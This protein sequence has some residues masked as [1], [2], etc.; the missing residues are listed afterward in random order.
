MPDTDIATQSEY[1]VPVA[2]D[3]ATVIREIRIAGSS[4]SSTE[5][6]PEAH[7]FIVG[8]GQDENEDL[9]EKIECVVLRQAMKIQGEWNDSDQNNRHYMYKSSEFNSFSDVVVLYDTHSIPSR[10][11]A[12]L[13]HSHRNPNLPSIGGKGERALKSKCNLRLRYVY[14]ILHNEEVFRLNG[15][16]TS[17][18]GATENDKP[19]G[20]D[21]PQEGSF[22]QFI[23]D[24]GDQPVFKFNCT[25]SGKKHS[26]KIMLPQFTKGEEAAAPAVDSFLSELYEGLSEAHWT[27]FGKAIDAT[28]VKSLDEWSQKIIEILQDKTFEPL[29]KGRSRDLF[30]PS[31]DSLPDVV[32]VKLIDAPASKMETDVGEIAGALQGDRPKVEDLPF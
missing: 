31:L 17:Y 8:Y 27:V 3:A 13:P 5:D 12:A 11:V 7:P 4:M 25:L 16:S 20:F 10:I 18:T 23:R 24:C 19:F 1:A 26:K 15:G 28:D 6:I 9:G 2:P 14:Y 32:D 29:L 30:K 21:K 22:M